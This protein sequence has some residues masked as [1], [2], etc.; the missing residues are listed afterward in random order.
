M[1][2]A[3]PAPEVGGRAVDLA[4]MRR[5]LDL[6]GTVRRRTSPNPW[7]GCVVVAGDRWFEGATEPPGGLHAEAL[8]LGEAGDDARGAT[9]YTTLEP[10]AHQGRTPPCAHAVV[11]AGVSRVVVG[12]EDPDPQVK[13]RGIALLRDSGI[14]VE[15]G[16]LEHEVTDLM[17]PYLKHRRSGLPW[18][19]LKLAC[20][21]DGRIAA[22]D[23]SSRWLTGPEAREDAHGLRADSDAILVC[24]GTVRADDP[25]LTV[26]FGQASER[27]PLHV[28][29]GAIAS[30]ARVEPALEMSGDPASA[31]CDLGAKGIVQ[32]LVEG[33]AHVAHSFH[34]AGLVDRYVLYFTPALFGGEDA[35]PMFAGRGAQDMDSLWRGRIVSAE[36]LGA[37]LR[38]DVEPGLCLPDGTGAT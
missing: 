28:V 30:G 5:A 33:G 2:P 22:P 1:T 26:R 9:L 17:A 15:V 29:L 16:I 7:V 31:L 25:E 13:G 4:P 10:C 35:V 21:M 38:V 12:I 6:A 23:G 19:V 34:R 36:R 11:R 27:Q 20:T 14:D 32:V 18:V 3:D 37:D 24:S 8:A